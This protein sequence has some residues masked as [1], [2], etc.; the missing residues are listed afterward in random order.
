MLWIDERICQR[1]WI[2]TTRLEARRQRAVHHRIVAHVVRCVELPGEL[3][4]VIL[5]KTVGI[6][7]WIKRWK[8]R[9]GHINRS[10]LAL[11]FLFRVA[12][13]KRH[14]KVLIHIPV[15]LTEHC[16]CVQLVTTSVIRV[17]LH[18]WVYLIMRVSGTKRCR[19]DHRVNRQYLPR[20]GQT[21]ASHVVA[22]SALVI[23][24]KAAK[25]EV[26]IA[27]KVRLHT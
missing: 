26:Q 15:E 24:H 25:H 27:V 4:L 1:Q 11:L 8:T 19:E 5:W 23:E 9:E 13:T 2:H 18:V 6:I 12:G 7:H 10:L 3:I 17:T 21:C 16:L 14:A 20:E 22:V